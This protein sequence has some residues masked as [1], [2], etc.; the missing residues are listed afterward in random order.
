MEV[1]KI[2]N[3]TWELDLQRINVKICAIQN[4]QWEHAS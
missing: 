3:T 4:M 1:E 2:M